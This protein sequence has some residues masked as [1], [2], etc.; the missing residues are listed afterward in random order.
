MLICFTQ[1][2][3]VV[4]RGG[5]SHWSA[6]QKWQS[7]HYI[8]EATRDLDI[9]VNF[10]PDG[11]GDCVKVNPLTGERV[12][13]KPHEETMPFSEFWSE[14]NSQDDQ[15]V[16]YAS[17]Q[18]DSFRQEFAPLETDV[19]GLRFADEAFNSTPDAV[20][21]W[22]GA[23]HI[24]F[25]NKLIDIVQLVK[26]FTGDERSVSAVHKDHYENMYCV[27]RGTKCFTLLPP[28]DAAF[29]HEQVSRSH[30]GYVPFQWNQ[31]KKIRMLSFL[32][33]DTDF[34]G[35]LLPIAPGLLMCVDHIN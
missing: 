15:R 6:C 23:F 26:W 28:C 7:D 34:P 16:P 25:I 19:A 21:L 18:N 14:L 24:P 20:N 32:S 2:R 35:S 9:S 33:L 4:I 10:T 5:I 22:I 29:M 12:F 8:V 30:L 17:H 11:H 27:V 13:V 31:F 1:N 3:P